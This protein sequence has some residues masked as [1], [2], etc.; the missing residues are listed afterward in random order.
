M[1]VLSLQHCIASLKKIIS[2]TTVPM[3]NPNHQNEHSCCVGTRSRWVAAA[4]SISP[5]L[6][7]F[8]LE[9]VFH[10]EESRL[11]YLGTTNRVRVER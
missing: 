1:L 2:V 11:Q 8:C 9:I 3:E 7:Q 4:S 10:I 5:F 6:E